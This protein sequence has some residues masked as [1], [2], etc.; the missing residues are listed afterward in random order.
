MNIYFILFIIVIP[1]TIF[2]ITLFSDKEFKKRLQ[3]LKTEVNIPF[4]TVTAIPQPQKSDKYYLDNG[5]GFGFGKEFFTNCEPKPAK[6]TDKQRQQNKKASIGIK[7]HKFKMNHNYNIRE[8]DDVVLKD[9]CSNDYLE[10]NFVNIINN[11][12]FQS[13]VNFYLRDVINEDEIDNLSKYYFTDPRDDI[14]YPKCEEIVNFK[15]N[16]I[17]FSGEIP[18]PIKITTKSI[19]ENQTTSVGLQTTSAMEPQTTQVYDA[20]NIYNLYSPKNIP[21]LN[22]KINPE[23]MPIPSHIKRKTEKEIRDMVSL[24]I[25]LLKRILGQ[26]NILNEEERKN[27]IR[28]IFFRMTDESKYLDDKD[29]H[30]YLVPYIEDD[31]AFILEGRNNRPLLVLSMYHKDCNK[32]EKVIESVSTNKTCGDWITRLLSNYNQLRSTEQEYN[33]LANIDL[34]LNPL[35]NCGPRVIESSPKINSEIKMLRDLEKTEMRKISIYKQKNNHI[36]HKK[37]ILNKNISE[38]DKLLNYDYKNDHQIKILKNYKNRRVSRIINENGN[39]KEVTLGYNELVNEKLNEIK[40][41]NEQRLNKL[42]K[43]NRILQEKINNYNKDLNN[44]NN[45]LDKIQDKINSKLNPKAI[46]VSTLTSLKRKIDTISKEI[47]APMYY[48]NNIRNILNINLVMLLLFGIISPKLSDKKLIE[49]NKNEPICNIL[50]I[51]LLNG[52]IT[53]SINNINDQILNNKSNHSY[54]DIDKLS[55]EKNMRNV[56]LAPKNNK[57][58]LFR[59]KNSNKCSILGAGN[60][61]LE[62]VNIPNVRMFCEQSKYYETGKLNALDINAQYYLVNELI[63]KVNQDQIKI[64]SKELE[65]LENFKKKI[66]FECT[67]CK[68]NDNTNYRAEPNFIKSSEKNKFFSKEEAIKNYEWLAGFIVRNRL[69]I[70]DDFIF[71]GVEYLN[72]NSDIFTEDLINGFFPKEPVVTDAIPCDILDKDNELMNVDTTLLNDYILKRQSCNNK[73]INS[74]KDSYI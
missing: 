10:K 32:M 24:D 66:E 7:F 41:R 31:F 34:V 56:I 18:E 1:F 61:K 27:T 37:K 51:N 46:N 16:P 45:K 74:F 67:G 68:F 40:Q 22:T 60:V 63:D 15:K 12:W 54:L 72:K 25:Y 48:A 69:N 5:I 62:S 50:K 57:N 65:A 39:K 19:D 70:H 35:N 29:L 9:Y 23:K 55:F 47:N 21:E 3:E 6:V 26:E 43:F 20:G 8:I 33:K 4:K 2:F 58:G 36:H 64:N 17:N 38:I 13:G 28:N 11:I 30:I 42:Y 59:G 14:V 71:Y 49:I 53:K 73:Y 44:L 52:G